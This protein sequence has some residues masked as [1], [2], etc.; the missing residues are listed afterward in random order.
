MPIDSAAKRA[1]VGGVP[2]HPLGV[3]VTPGTL[4]TFLGRAAAA[5]TYGGNDL[6]PP[7]GGGVVRELTTL[8]TVLSLAVVPDPVLGGR[9]SW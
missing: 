8:G 4:G 5:W 3:N 6:T 2:A 7:V 9:G 1:A